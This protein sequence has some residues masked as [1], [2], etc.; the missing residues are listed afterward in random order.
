VQ[1]RP[2]SQPA[3][4][5]PPSGDGRAD[6]LISQSEFDRLEAEF[7]EI[8]DEILK[9]PDNA[10]K[11]R[12]PWLFVGSLFLEFL[13]VMYAFWPSNSPN[14]H[15]QKPSPWPAGYAELFM[16]DC[17]TLVSF[18]GT[19]TLTLADDQTA[20][21]E[22]RSRKATAETVEGRWTYDANST[23]YQVHLSDGAETYSLA[24]IEH[25]GHCMLIKGDLNSAN[26]N[27]S[28]FSRRRGQSVYPDE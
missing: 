28:W 26:L 21:L 12:K 1:K 3:D 22:M 25:T 2:A 8:P 19:K 18:D 27:A 15:L 11:L 24:S 20:S 17:L 23:R 9:I 4:A 13:A 14:D 6:D 10:P 5:P 16:S 7:S